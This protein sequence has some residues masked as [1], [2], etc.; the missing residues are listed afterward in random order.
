[1]SIAYARHTRLSPPHWARTRVPPR[2]IVKHCAG[3]TITSPCGLLSRAGRGVCLCCRQKGWGRAL[4][5]QPP[6]WN[7]ASL[8]QRRRHRHC[9]ACGCRLLR[10]ADSRHLDADGV[11][12]P[13]GHCGVCGGGWE[14]ASFSPPPAPRTHMVGPREQR[15]VL[16]VGCCETAHSEEGGGVGRAPHVRRS[17]GGA[18][19]CWVAPAPS[20]RLRF[21]ML[22]SCLPTQIGC[23]LRRRVG[24]GPQH[25]TVW[26]PLALLCP[27]HPRAS[28]LN[29][30]SHSHAHIHVHAHTHSPPSC[31][32]RSPSQ[33]WEC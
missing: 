20:V 29:S 14:A 13:P 2:D 10:S 23:A 22:P 17:P 30:H 4:P 11:S 27:K 5:S 15:P 8:R 26:R 7:D 28:A 21:V 9:G 12:A 31:C 18:L 25:R 33:Q 16:A 6:L 3:R 32:C 1:M 19:P 24:L